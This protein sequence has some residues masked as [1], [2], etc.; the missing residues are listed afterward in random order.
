MHRNDLLT[1]V[2]TALVTAT[3]T[4]VVSGPFSHANADAEKSRPKPIGD[5]GAVDGAQ[6]RLTVTPEKPSPGDKLTLR[7]AASNPQAHS[8]Q[9][10]AKAVVQRRQA[11]EVVSR[12]AAVSREAWEGSCP[13]SLEANESRDFTVSTTVAAA[14]GDTFIVNVLAG[15]EVIMT[16]SVTVPGAP[17][18][19]LLQAEPAPAKGN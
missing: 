11:V 13:I 12:M 9:F 10:T 2:T 19:Q 4:V 8:V 17:V 18:L 1:F 7:I 14:A 16:T 5:T 15:S 3:L 6:F